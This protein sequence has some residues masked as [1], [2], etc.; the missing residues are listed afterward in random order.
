M[1]VIEKADGRKFA[2]VM[3]SPQDIDTLISA[4]QAARS[5]KSTRLNQNEI[6]YALDR[7]KFWK[8]DMER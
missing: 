4:L 1:K 8:R 6:G 7:A 3:L 2:Q 5:S